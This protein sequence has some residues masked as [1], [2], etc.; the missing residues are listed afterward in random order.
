MHG[1]Q[2]VIASTTND[3]TVRLGVGLTRITET[4]AKENYQLWIKFDNGYEG[5]V[6]LRE[7]VGK[8]V[9]KAWENE[10]VLKQVE[11]DPIA[12]TVFWLNGEIDLDPDVLYEDILKK[13]A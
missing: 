3:S 9:F 7:Y 8:G 5:V 12:K 10:E 11:I 4:T 13:S 2:P 1:I 6:Y